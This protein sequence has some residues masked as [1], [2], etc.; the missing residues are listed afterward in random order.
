MKDLKVYISVGISIITLVFGGLKGYAILQEN[1][2]D[3]DGKSTTHSEKLEKHDDRLRTVE[4]H[5]AT[6]TAQ[7]EYIGEGMREQKVVNKEILKAIMDLK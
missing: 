2:K 5:I 6:Q 1:V 4:T 3:L 7:L